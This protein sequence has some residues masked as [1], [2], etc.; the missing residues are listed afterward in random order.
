VCP[1]DQDPLP[2]AT[3]TRTFRLLVEYDGTDFCGWQIQPAG[4]TIQGELERALSIILREPVRLIGS[5]RTDAGT[6][7]L[8]QV[9]HFRTTTRLPSERL[10]RALN[11]LLPTD[12][13][14]HD[15]REA[16]AE[17]HARYSARRKRYR[18]RIH[19]GKAALTRRFVWCLHQSLDLEA[20]DAAAS[21][22]LGRH[23]FGAFC[24][25]DPV[26]ANPVC[27]VYDIQL[28]ARGRE[29][30]LEIEADRFLRHMVRIIMGTL[31]EVGT[32]SRPAD[33]IARLLDEGDRRA[34]GRTAPACGLCLLW[35]EYPGLPSPDIPPVRC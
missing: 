28:V 14:I 18:Y 25:Q 10:C 20:M 7:A 2:D 8:G 34:A 22:L 24:K 19:R 5:G 16:A 27:T 31:V 13:A 30:I 33:D 9:A 4:R 29:V 17:F 3:G 6:H 21:A 32:H 26:P 23:A 1:P 12:I 15:V 35:V 11:G